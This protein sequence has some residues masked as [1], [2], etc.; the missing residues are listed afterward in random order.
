LVAIALLTQ[1]GAWAGEKG[2][3]GGDACELRIQT[4]R[5]DLKKW[6]ADGGAKHLKL[7]TTLD[8]DAYKKKSN[9]CD[10]RRRGELHI[11]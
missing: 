9:R 11:R 6:I 10:D 3:N 1:S 2:G 7:P 5:E 4:I 8:A